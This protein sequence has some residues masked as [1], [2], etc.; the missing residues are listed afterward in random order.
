MYIYINIWFRRA[1]GLGELGGLW[2]WG[3]NALGV[4]VVVAKC[5]GTS[6]HLQSPRQMALTGG[7][8]VHD[9]VQTHVPTVGSS[10]V[11]DIYSKRKRET[12]TRHNAPCPPRRCR[13]AANT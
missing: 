6:A 4:E 12:N 13:F 9:T 11:Q 8:Y 7:L 3:F 10:A 2:G 5:V 1:L